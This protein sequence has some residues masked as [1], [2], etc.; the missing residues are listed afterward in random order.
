M[1]NEDFSSPC[2]FPRLSLRARA[3]SVSWAPSGSGM[4]VGSSGD[5]I[6]MPLGELTRY[7]DIIS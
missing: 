2:Y 5:I 7:P 3:A 4:S 6:G 1:R